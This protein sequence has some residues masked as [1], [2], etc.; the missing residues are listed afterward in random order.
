MVVYGQQLVTGEEL[1]ER[2]MGAFKEPHGG[3][4]RELYLGE[5]AAEE[6]KRRANDYPSW[7]L[8]PRQL[9]DLEMLLSGAF[10]PLAGFH[11][12]AEYRSVLETMRL[13]AG[14]LWPMPI[15]LDVSEAFAGSIEIGQTIALRDPEGV[16]VAVMTIEACWA[17][18]KHLEADAVYASRDEA[19]LGVRRLLR[20]VHP[21]YLGGPVHG[22]APPSHYDFKLLRDAPSELRWRFRKLGW[23]RV[24]A[25][26]PNGAMHRAEQALSFK[27]ARENE[28][29]LLIQ[30]LVGP[31]HP[32]ELSHFTRVRCFEHVLETYPEQTTAL[33]LLNMASRFAGPREVMWQAIVRKN[34]GCT[35][36]VVQ[37]GDGD[38]DQGLGDALFYDPNLA[39]T[40]FAEHEAEL[41]ITMVPCD[42]MVYVEG[43]AEHLPAGE[44]GPHMNTVEFGR[45]ELR[46]R[47]DEDLALPDWFSFPKVVDE[48]R[49]AYP[50]RSKQGFTVFFT[51]LSGS[52][53]STIANALMVKLREIGG[54]PVTLLDGDIVRKRLSSEL[55]FSKEH[56]DLNI[57]RAG[58]VAAEI[59][60]NGGVAICAP[61][62]PYAQTR[63][64]VREMVEA[65]GGF[66]EVH[67]ATSLE[68]C[69]RRDRKGLYARARAGLV[70]EFTGVSDPYEV[71]ASPELRIDTAELSAE[72][73]AHRVLIALERMGFVR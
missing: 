48:L 12:Q 43:R 47:L 36:F 23:R 52:G 40:L 19:H 33:S 59:A 21:V 46:R 17:A 69:E 18:D 64:Q 63:Q 16:L 58:F 28:A 8:A 13:L 65:V 20:D 22:I 31:G 73:A 27:A 15:V 4:L 35:H 55:G 10:S 25:Y 67:V 41:N 26:Q 61:I 14:V 68:V 39:R 7:D 54:R 44:V 53:K 49:A 5:A 71:P 66:I 45:A 56:R 72:L 70:K 2:S 32:G 3:Q 57:L 60:K 62:A 34:Y 42:E 50:P 38:P 6:E 37:P 9:A 24:V 51:G 29:N 1:L 11:T 30:P